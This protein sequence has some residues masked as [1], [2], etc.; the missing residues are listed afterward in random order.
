LFSKTLKINNNNN[1]K[2]EDDDNDC[3]LIEDND[4]EKVWDSNKKQI[5]NNFSLFRNLMN[6]KNETNI[7]VIIDN[8]LKENFKDTL[9]KLN[10]NKFSLEK[11][12]YFLK[13]EFDE[14]IN[15]NTI[16]KISSKTYIYK[17]KNI[18]YI[19]IF[20]LNQY[21]LYIY[22]LQ[23]S[24]IIDAQKYKILYQINHYSFKNPFITP[25]IN[26]YYCCINFFNENNYFNNEK[27][28]KDFIDLMKQIIIE[29][30]TNY[31]QYFSDDNDDDDDD[32][33]L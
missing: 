5:I 26:Y 32:G 23:S 24:K 16:P 2:I 22:D 6:K 18:R 15:N 11:Y 28:K 19:V 4:I 3:I 29:F 25:T 31:C 8:F 12:L 30:N 33:I 27:K 20:D 7:F 21:P 17:M 1:I 9:Q 14:K 13:K 10:Q